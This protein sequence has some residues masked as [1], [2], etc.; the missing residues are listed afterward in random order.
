[1]LCTVATVIADDDDD[2]IESRTHSSHN[3]E[4]PLTSSPEMSPI[5]G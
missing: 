5:L 1:M 2:E 4:K 3:S